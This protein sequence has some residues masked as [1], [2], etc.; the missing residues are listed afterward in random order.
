MVFRD[1]GHKFLAAVLDSITP[2]SYD[3]NQWAVIGPALLTSV[4]NAP[5]PVSSRSN[6]LHKSWNVDVLPA[7]KFYPLDW[8]RVQSCFAEQSI[9]LQMWPFLQRF[10]YTLHLYTHQMTAVACDFRKTHG[11]TCSLDAAIFGGHDYRTTSKGVGAGDLSTNSE[12]SSLF[13]VS[14]SVFRVLPNRSVL[15]PSSPHLSVAPSDFHVESQRH[16]FFVSQYKLRLG[17]CDSSRKRYHARKY[18]DDT[19]SHHAPTSKSTDGVLFVQDFN[20]CLS[21]GGGAVGNYW[22]QSAIPRNTTLD[23]G[24]AAAS[25]HVVMEFGR[26]NTEAHDKDATGDQQSGAVTLETT[27]PCLERECNVDFHFCAEAD[28]VPGWQQSPSPESSSSPQN[29]LVVV[30]I[31]VPLWTRG[32]T[33]ERQ[34]K[35]LDSA[36]VAGRGLRICLVSDVLALKGVDSLNCHRFEIVPAWNNRRQKSHHAGELPRGEAACGKNIIDSW[37]RLKLNARDIPFPAMGS[38][39]QLAA[40]QFQVVMR[41]PS[42]VW[43][44]G[45]HMMTTSYSTRTRSAIVVDHSHSTLA[46]GSEALAQMQWELVS[47]DAAKRLNHRPSAFVTGSTTASGGVVQ[48]DPGSECVV[49]PPPEDDG[50]SKLKAELQCNAESLDIEFALES[51]AAAATHGLQ[52]FVLVV[53]DTSTNRAAQLCFNFRQWHK[54]CMSVEFVVPNIWVQRTL[55]F[56]AIFGAAVVEPVIEVVMV[57]PS[58]SSPAKGVDMEDDVNPRSRLYFRGSVFPAADNARPCR[59]LISDS[60]A[61]VSANVVKHPDTGNLI[62]PGVAS[63]PQRFY[64]Y[65]GDAFDFEECLACYSRLHHGRSILTHETRDTAQG[66]ANILLRRDLE[67]HPLRTLDPAQASVFVVDVFSIASWK[68]QSGA[69]ARLTAIAKDEDGLGDEGSSD[70]VQGIQR[71]AGV[72]SCGGLTH[73]ERMERVRKAVQDSPWYAAFPFLALL[74]GRAHFCS[75]HASNFFSFLPSFLSVCCHCMSGSKG[76]LVGIT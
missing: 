5:P 76:T 72:A 8:R 57:I 43:V 49:L 6:V 1:D 62:G 30:V 61:S 70:S 59:P 53:R 32:T 11:K 40:I 3:I 46:A 27:L 10:S 69:M 48:C 36:L 44:K 20:W 63:S 65:N 4:L 18:V 22:L 71:I 68:V 58:I 64:L 21:S 15:N 12:E 29:G 25:S 50:A 35:P 13:S 66:T 2:Q 17:S 60:C 51:R 41:Q 28:D 47:E 14:L 42:K 26:V 55:D 33:G 16:N 54:D 34:T 37:I 73:S 7:Y 39:R 67:A 9:C 24:R 52:P 56:V 31:F 75:A 74:L 19:G 38:S 45:G 23:R